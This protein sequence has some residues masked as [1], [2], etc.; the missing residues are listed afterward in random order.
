MAKPDKPK[1]APDTFLS[2][3]IELRDRL[4]RSALAVLLLFLALSPFANP[5]YTYFAAPL[6]AALPEGNTMISTQPHGTFFVP[7]K[8]AF[9]AALLLAMPYLL[10]QIWSFVAPGLYEKEKRFAFPALASSV[11][12][13]FLGMAFAYFLVFPTIFKFFAATTPEGVA[14]MTEIDSYLNFALTLF[15]AFGVTFEVPVLTV[16]LVKVGAVSTAMLREQ[17]PYIIVGCFVIAAV[18]TPP[19]VFSQISMA[20]PMWLLFELGL[21]VARYVEPKPEPEPEP[22]P[23]DAAPVEYA[24]KFEKLDAEG[25]EREMAEAES[26]FA[27][28]EKPKPDPS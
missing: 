6:M 22:E 17:R 16:L 14:M 4:L 28:L 8:L 21:F 23:E 24:E 1:P 19:D 9:F 15:L 2:H 26:Q 27:E 25:M 13:F 10:Y 11:V 7:F 20:V 5:L 12:L 18:L 3:L